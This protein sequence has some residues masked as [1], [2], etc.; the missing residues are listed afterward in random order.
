MRVL[1]HW[2]FVAMALVGMLI[3]ILQRLGIP[4]PSIINNYLNDMLSIPI[5]LFIILGVVRT[6]RGKAYLL[7]VPMIISVVAYY[8]IYFEYYLPMYHPRYTA[9]ILDIGCYSLGGIIFYLNQ[10]YLLTTQH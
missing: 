4:L 9:D 3:Y 5:T 7:S 8:A 1:R 2:T 10:R 6:W